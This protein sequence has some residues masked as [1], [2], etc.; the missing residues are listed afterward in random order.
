MSDSR[1]DDWRGAGFMLLAMA[2]YGFNDLM[3]KIA[4]ASLP[5]STILAVR[6]TLAAVFLLIILKWRR[7]LW[8]VRPSLKGRAM[9]RSVLDSMAT[10]CY[11]YALT[12]LSLPNAAA[13]YQLTP[14]VFMLAS[15]VMLREVIPLRGWLGTMIGFA[16]VLCVI[17]PDSAVLDLHTLAVVAAVLFSAGRD[18]LMRDS[19]MPSPVCLALFSAVCTAVVGLGQVAI[20]DPAGIPTPGGF[21]LLLVAAT[22]ISVGYIFLALATATGGSGFVSP[23][24]YSI[25]VYATIL[26][27]V[28][29]GQYPGWIGI[30]G[31]AMI[32][33]GG[34]I[35]TLGPSRR[36]RI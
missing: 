10:V 30:L 6:S 19:M 7:E 31:I 17:R 25:L 11:V 34:T 4:T 26:G 9:L 12:G 18:L 32:L 23:F 14:I 24:R 36:K 1:P 16:G 8:Q 28:V 2:G 27:A 33:L 29:L 5:A 20:T 13:I 3:V 15:A 35:A 21:A 22:A